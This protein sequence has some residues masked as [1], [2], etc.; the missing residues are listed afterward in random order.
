MS[1]LSEQPL[2]VARSFLFS[3]F[4]LLLASGKVSAMPVFINELHYDNIGADVGEGVELTGPAGANLQGWRLWFYNGSNGSSYRS[5]SL[6]GVFAD[7]QNGMGVLDFA[8]SGIQNGSPD[9]IALVD[10]NSRVQQFI[11][12]EGAFMALN[13]IAEN[14]LSQDIG[15][16]ENAQTP[17]GYSLQLSGVG[18]GYSD[19][20]WRTG[21]SSFGAINEQQRF[22]RQVI[23]EGKVPVGSSGL[24]LS[25][26]LIGLVLRSAGR[27]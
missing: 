11:S 16:A 19:F 7:M 1:A 23:E 3:I 15:V 21:S 6:S 5:L 14:L 26:G 8:F 24:L 12:Y 13:G 20:Q 17:I 4:L 10:G 18:A 9:G 2:R 25:L 27:P 22:N